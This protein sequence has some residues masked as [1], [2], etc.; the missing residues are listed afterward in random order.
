MDDRVIRAALEQYGLADAPWKLIRHNENMTVHVDDRY[1][2]RV[3]V[4]ADGF[5]TDALYKGH[6]RA[7]IRRTEL[8][9][10]LWLSERGMKVQTP[11]PNQRGECL[12]LLPGGVMATML[13]WLPGRTPEEK[14]AS[15]DLFRRVG[16]VTAQMHQA[17]VGFHAD[18]LLRYDDT[19]C[20][21]L[22]AWLAKARSKGML[23]GEHAD[24]MQAACQVMERR[25][26]PDSSHII[27]HCDLS[28][29]NMLIT[30]DGLVPIDFSLM[31]LAH[32][33]M[34]IAMLFCSTSGLWVRQRI[35]E[36]Y[37]AHGGL[38]AYPELDAYY[39]LNILLYIVLHLNGKAAQEGF[40]ANMGRW[41]AQTF[42]PLSEGKRL[43]D[44][45]FFLI[46][47]P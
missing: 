32:P 28:S 25:M 13:T 20:A 19:L 9:F 22:Q 15:D 8:D 43:F 23:S 18:E 6:D 4:H 42:R 44:D 30:D 7:A 35:A 2:L 12:T 45:D 24:V 17:A 36:G 26:R 10:L 27:A 3:H 21:R 47:V 29:S 14:D 31:G 16:A 5:S 40:V 11:V 34:D 39:A 33:M 38:I 46:N 37:R 1:L 41:C